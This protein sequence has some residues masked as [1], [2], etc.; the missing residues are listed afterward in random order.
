MLDTGDALAGGNRLGDRTSGEAIV[1]GMNLMG[2]DAMALGPKEL[3]LGPEVLTERLEEAQFE[4]VAA[5]V[6]HAATG[7]PVVEPFAVVGVGGYRVGIIGLTREPDPPLRQFMVA[8]PQETLTT[9]L[10]DVKPQS[11]F[12]IVLTNVRQEEAV[13]LGESDRQIGLVVSALAESV[14]VSPPRAAVSNAM[15]LVADRALPR[16]TGRYLGRLSATLQ[17][18]GKLSDEEWEMVA[19]LPEIKDDREMSRLLDSFMSNN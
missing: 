2:Y 12:T 16:H 5:N 15:V 17:P 13:T 7:E 19:M 1:A 3:E 10:P 9:I 18:N 4:V 11:D 6:K 14:R 8:D